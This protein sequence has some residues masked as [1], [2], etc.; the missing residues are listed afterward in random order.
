VRSCRGTGCECRTAGGTPAAR[1][2]GI[3]PARQGTHHWRPT[4]FLT[5]VPATLTA[6][7]LPAVVRAAPIEPCQPA[8]AQVSVRAQTHGRPLII[9]WCVLRASPVASVKGG[10]RSFAALRGGKSRASLPVPAWL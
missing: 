2:V 6:V 7:P 5:M 9:E 10:Q 3:S 8:G 4:G 1:A